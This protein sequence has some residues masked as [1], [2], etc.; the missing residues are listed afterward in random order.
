MFISKG[1]WTQGLFKATAFCSDDRYQ[2]IPQP[3]VLTVNIYNSVPMVIDFPR[4]NMKCSGE[5]V[6]L[7]AE[8]FMQ[9]LGFLYISCY[10]AEIWIPIGL[11]VRT[12][13]PLD[14][15]LERLKNQVCFQS[16]SFPAKRGNSVVERVRMQGI[17]R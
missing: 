16:G 12:R 6:I 10:T 11:V 1:K 8:Y 14:G 2:A 3:S 17:W 9:Y 4:Q 15:L 13:L 5:N 7:Y